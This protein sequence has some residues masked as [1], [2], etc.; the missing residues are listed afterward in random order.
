[1]K[2][3]FILKDKLSV[4]LCENPLVKQTCFL[5]IAHHSCEAANQF[6]KDRKAVWF[7]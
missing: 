2:K 4:L 7:S 3:I 1:M 6:F 5:F